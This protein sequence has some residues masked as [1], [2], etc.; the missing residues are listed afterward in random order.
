MPPAVTK[1]L[2]YVRAACALPVLGLQLSGFVIAPGVG[3]LA[4]CDTGFG[5]RL[6][7][8]LSG[9][10]ATGEIRALLLEHHLG[11]AGGGSGNVGRNAVDASG[12]SLV[13]AFYAKLVWI[14]PFNQRN[15]AVVRC[16]VACSTP[17]YSC[18][19]I[20][21]CCVVQCTSGYF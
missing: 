9:G 11:K 3:M 1:L 12:V 18:L 4:M 13:S 14:I 20:L 10:E 5:A 6:C 21:G 16:S 17:E 19:T 7:L 2:P 8:R 15:S